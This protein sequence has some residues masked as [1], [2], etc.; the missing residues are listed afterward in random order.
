MQRERE[1]ERDERERVVGDQNNNIS[2][3]GNGILNSKRER[4]NERHIIA[5]PTS[6]SLFLLIPE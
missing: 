2:V 4:E 3:L 6:L 1:R 5:P